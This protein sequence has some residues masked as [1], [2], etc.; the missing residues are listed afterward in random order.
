MKKLIY[1]LL[2]CS[3]LF[4]CKKSTDAT[5]NL[6]EF[7]E[8]EVSTTNDFNKNY[9]LKANISPNPNAT[10]SEYGFVYSYLHP[11]FD[12]MFNDS[13]KTLYTYNGS[14]SQAQNFE[15]TIYNLGLAVDYAIKTYAIN[16]GRI[17]F[18]KEIKVSPTG[19]NI[20]KINSP[21]FTN[22][23]V[24]AFALS[25]DS[26]AIIGGGK[27]NNLYSTFDGNTQQFS[28]PADTLPVDFANES[29]ATF[30]LGNYGYVVGGS[31]NN[32]ASSQVYRYEFATKTWLKMNNFAGGARIAA[33]AAV[34]NGKAYVGFGT[35]LS[36]NLADFWEYNE[37]NDTWTQINI[38][39]AEINGR[40]SSSCFV[41]GDN[42]YI[43]GGNT[44]SALS[45]VVYTNNFWQYN[46]KEGKWNVLPKCPFT[47]GNCFS[48]TYKNEAL[49]GFGVI[50]KKS[51]L[52]VGYSES[53]KKWFGYYDGN[54]GDLQ[55]GE[56][57][58]SL[59]VNNKYMVANFY[60]NEILRIR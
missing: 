60:K 16:D 57:A 51:N 31:K 8:I 12:E 14:L 25:N 13:L 7:T 9:V 38:N 40:N 48:F 49:I 53:N 52:I 22:G 17:T 26:T 42:I 36:N 34:A 45:S 20:E 32:V 4:S 37:S 10:I 1:S 23:A 27:D 43:V 3:V 28:E 2:F 39:N 29:C 55:S 50:N 21:S 59:I 46:T 33:V 44:S 30:T 19:A 24:N 54:N 56:K 18:G 47:S 35:N 11:V 58:Y 6:S 15:D 5:I 41:L